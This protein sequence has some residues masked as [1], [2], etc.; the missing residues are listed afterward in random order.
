MRAECQTFMGNQAAVRR[1]ELAKKAVSATQHTNVR[2]DDPW[3]WPRLHQFDGAE[4]S[5]SWGSLVP[6]RSLPRHNHHIQLQLKQ[7]RYDNYEAKH[8][9]WSV[10]NCS[11]SQWTMNAFIRLSLWP[12]G[13]T[14]IHPSFLYNYC[15][16]LLAKRYGNSPTVLGLS[17][18]KYGTWKY[19]VL[20]MM[21]EVWRYAHDTAEHLS[22][23]L[24]SLAEQTN[25]FTDK[26]KTNQIISMK[27]LWCQVMRVTCPASRFLNTRKGL[28]SFTLLPPP[29]QA[30][31]V[32]CVTS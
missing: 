13:L 5:E 19:L 11:N 18:S 3:S 2:D 6:Y 9:H 20:R 7:Q 32:K 15:N 8:R 27:L 24:S 26:R 10:Y 21:P 14:K 1:L 12:N 17:A 25:I 28:G 22:P 23:D 30:F 16:Q 31:R 4:V 29:P